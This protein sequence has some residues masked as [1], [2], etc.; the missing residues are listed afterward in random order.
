MSRDE[1]FPL[2]PQ[3]M[4]GLVLG[5]ICFWERW[6]TMYHFLHTVPLWLQNSRKAEW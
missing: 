6:V 2:Y 1:H 3:E 4:E 5:Y